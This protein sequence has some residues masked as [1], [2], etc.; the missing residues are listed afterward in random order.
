LHFLADR[1]VF[2]LADWLAALSEAPASHFRQ[3]RG[4][5]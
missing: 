1:L 5:P 3:Q 4:Q 2:D